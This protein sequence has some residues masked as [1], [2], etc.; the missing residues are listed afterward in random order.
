M[1]TGKMMNAVLTTAFLWLAASSAGAQEFPSK[2]IKLTSPYSAGSGPD[3]IARAVAEKMSKTWGQQVIVDA[4]PG[5]NG[6]IAMEAVK[7][8]PADGHDLA[9]VGNA[10]MTINPALF[11]KLPYDAKADFAPVA[12]LYSTP[13]FIA[14]SANGPYRTMADLIADAKANPGKI[15]YGS[16]Y[17]GSPSHLGSALLESSTDTKMIHVPFKD[18]LQIFTSIANGDVG[19]ALGTLGTAGALVRAGKIKLI[20]VAARKRLPSHPDIPTV[21]EAAGLKGFDV[22]A[23][24]AVMAPRRTPPAVVQRINAEV[25]KILDQPDVKDRLTALGFVPA[26][27]TPEGLAQTID[28]DLKKYGELVKRTGASAE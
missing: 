6:F 28:R 11:R 16:P 9:I 14:V 22:D 26:P 20:A 10:H 27:D 15:S 18:A 1:K 13:F 3:V 24:V 19:W 12:M 8:A 5:A 4:R 2:V 17:I 21:D 23:W 25:N 7:R